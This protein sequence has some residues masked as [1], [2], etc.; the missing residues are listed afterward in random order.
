[1]KKKYLESDY[2]RNKVN[3]I[4]PANKRRQAQTL[5]GISM[6]YLIKMRTCYRWNENMYEKEDCIL[7]YINT[8]NIQ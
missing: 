5:K 8:N 6:Y 3:I 1:M 7:V 2:I 4:L